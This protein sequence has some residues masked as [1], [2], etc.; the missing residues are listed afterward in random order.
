MG[1]CVRGVVSVVVR[2]VVSAVVPSVFSVAVSFVFIGES[3]VSA[4]VGGVL[5]V[6][7]GKFIEDGAHGLPRVQSV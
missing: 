7:G 1:R 2:G 5:S 3:V 6:N 4:I